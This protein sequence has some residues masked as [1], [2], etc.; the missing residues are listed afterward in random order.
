MLITIVAGQVQNKAKNVC[1]V[2]DLVLPVGTVKGHLE[3]LGISPREE[4]NKR[5]MCRAGDAG[6][7]GKGGKQGKKECFM[8]MQ[9]DRGG[10][11]EN[12]GLEKKKVKN[13][14]QRKREFLCYVSTW[15]VSR[16]REEASEFTWE[17]DAMWNISKQ[18]SSLFSKRLFLQS[19][20]FLLFV[21][22]VLGAWHPNLE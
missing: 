11:K 15:V 20:L 3:E 22:T 14:A 4:K 13:E 16:R 18:K 2:A 1:K 5:L 9:G 17:E 10:H 6:D 8:R 12:V 19:S 7:G 21:Q